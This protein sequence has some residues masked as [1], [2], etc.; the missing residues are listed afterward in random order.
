MV[1]KQQEVDYTDPEAAAHTTTV[2]QRIYLPVDMITHI[3]A[4]LVWEIL[5]ILVVW[6]PRGQEAHWWREWGVHLQ[7]EMQALQTQRRA[8]EG[9]RHRKLQAHETQGVQ[10]DQIRHETGEDLQARRQFHL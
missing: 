9:E 1:E 4:N 2:S 10:E 6:S 8:V 7:D 3:G 5:N